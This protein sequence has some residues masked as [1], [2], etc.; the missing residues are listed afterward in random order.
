MKTF[1]SVVQF[2]D[3]FNDVSILSKLDGRICVGSLTDILDWRNGLDR[4]LHGRRIALID[5]QKFESKE[6]S[7]LS[8]N[9]CGSPSIKLF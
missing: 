7:G 9:F 4:K 5:A 3:V 1:D 6:N 2:F 8:S